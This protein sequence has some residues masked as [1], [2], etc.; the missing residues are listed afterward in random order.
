VARVAVLINTTHPAAAAMATDAITWLEANGHGTLVLELPEAE[1]ADHDALEGCDLAVS[2]GGDGTFL[3]LVPLAYAAGIPVLGVNFGRL[4]YLLEVQP[5]RFPEA[6]RLAVGGEVS[7]EERLALAVMVRGELSPPPAGERPSSG[8][9]LVDS[10]GAR[11]WVALNEVVTEKTVPG[12]MVHLSTTVDGEPALSYQA[13]GVLVATPTGSTAYN[14]SAGGPLLAP[15]L[16]A[17]IVTAVAPHRSIDRSLVLDADRVIT[18][19]VLPHR[20]AVLV[21]DGR[22]VGRLAP[23]AEVVCRAA[24]SPVRIVTLGG[25][26][27]AGTVRTTFSFD[28]N[29]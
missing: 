21:V 10:D 3:R 18:V 19:K 29:G 17:L 16:Q 5:D 7:V 24:P 14:L 1:R 11:W 8:G 13:D 22:A 15:G 20:P 27:F 9:G 12:H 6:L 4:G 26:S 25:R 2:L 23:G 28:A